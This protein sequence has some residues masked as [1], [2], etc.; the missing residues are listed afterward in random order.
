MKGAP[1]APL[2]EIRNVTDFS[3]GTG[4]IT[5]WAEGL[6]GWFEIEPA[7]AYQSIY[8]EMCEGIVLYYNIADSYTSAREAKKA[9]FRYK[10]ALNVDALLD[11]YVNSLEEPISRQEAADRCYQHREF[12]MTQ[13]CKPNEPVQWIKSSFFKWLCQVIILGQNSITGA[14]TT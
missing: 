8:E 3:F 7:A 14:Y 6:A 9:D 10:R 5:I 13:M 12:L 4:P 2:I 11:G 1:K